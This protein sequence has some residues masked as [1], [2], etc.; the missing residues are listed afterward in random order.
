[1]PSPLT[2]PA[3]L[4]V[5]YKR[6]ALDERGVDPDPFRQFARWF[7]EAVAA[8]VPEPNAMTVASVDAA[9]RP[10]ARI[11]LLKGVDER[12]FVFYT[13][14]GSR[15]GR[16]LAAGRYAALLFFWA[17]LERQVRVEGVVERVDDAESDAYFALRPRA[18]QLGAWASPQS[19]V[20]ADRAWLDAQYA[21]CE[22]RYGDDIPRPPHWGGI[23]VIPDRFEFWQGRP[24]R[25]HDRLEWLR[26]TEGW[27]IR[28]LAP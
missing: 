1:M 10:A 28:R 3:K 6:A 8:A 7:D 15:K 13:N 20:I 4:R 26:A 14:Y 12:G 21:A 19:A 16:E 27:T 24:S 9:G 22:A 5:D 23:R 17:E 11:L 2:D 18:S 25:L